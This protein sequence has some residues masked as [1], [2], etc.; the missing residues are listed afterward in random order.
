MISLILI[1]LFFYIF[2]GIATSQSNEDTEV[3]ICVPAWAN[4]TTISVVKDAA[5]A[6]GFKVLSTISQ[7]AAACLSYDQLDDN[8]ENS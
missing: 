8:K 1:Y 7:P 2:I 4:D 5:H 6:V 3:T